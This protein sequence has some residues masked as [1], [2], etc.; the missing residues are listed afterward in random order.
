MKTARVLIVEDE[1]PIARTLEL[2]IKKLANDYFEIVGKA[3]NGK[4]ALD[5][6]Q[7]KQVDIVFTDIR[8][9]V[10]DGLAL[11]EEMHT[12]YP[13]VS[14]VVL[15]GYQDFNY[16]QKSLRFGVVDYLL[17][18]IDITELDKLLEKLKIS[19]QIKVNRNKQA[20][21]G[22][23]LKGHQK[24][25]SHPEPNCTVMLI[26]AG[27]FPMVTDDILLSGN[28]FWR[29]I[30]LESIL[31]ELTA[32]NGDSFIFDGQ[33]SVEKRIVI[34]RNDSC[35]DLVNA[36]FKK[37]DSLSSI[38]ITA[39]SHK[40]KIPFTMVGDTIRTMRASLYREIKICSSQMLWSKKRTYRKEKITVDATVINNIVTSI[41]ANNE[42][43][44][45]AELSEFLYTRSDGITQLEFSQILDI[46]ISDGRLIN[47]FSHIDPEIKI[48]ITDAISYSTSIQD[49]CRDVTS[50]LLSLG[51]STSLK[52]KRET[53]EIVEQVEQYLILN[54][55]KSISNELLSK[56]FGFGPSYL[57]KIFRAVKGM[58][59]SEY[60][61]HYRVEKA[62]ELFVEH[63]NMKVYDVAN[64]IGMTDQYYFSK[65]FKKTTGVWPKEFINSNK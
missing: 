57:S 42:E 55:S 50:V 52:G 7:N 27:A 38:S 31:K 28:S 54:Y 35:E 5:Q 16:A 45:L 6:M 2:S 46:I 32:G 48:Q 64:A 41:C 3:I 59:P 44:L 30:D 8:M 18:P 60:L 39:V 62:K 13:E 21:L 37:L 51:E 36:I 65:L 47:N 63:P 26:C 20:D 29:K 9:P 40:E 23:M 17:K 24:L 22:L 19:H 49:L 53:N 43:N 12:G 25:R 15:S 4:D 11:L 56:K 34:E 33:T 1:P 58:S 61:S 14:T 10:M